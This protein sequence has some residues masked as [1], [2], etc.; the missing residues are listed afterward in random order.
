M[1]FSRPVGPNAIKAL[2]ES[3]EK[4]RCLVTIHEKKKK[5]KKEIKMTE[6]F[7]NREIKNQ[8]A[9]GDT[10]ARLTPS[11][12]RKIPIGEILNREIG[13]QRNV[14]KRFER[15]L[16]SSVAALYE[17]RMILVVRRS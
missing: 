15:A 14:N 17:R 1:F 12:G 10:G 13:T 3:L 5:K 2:S 16:N 7:Q 8:V 11:G 9:N 4:I 6:L